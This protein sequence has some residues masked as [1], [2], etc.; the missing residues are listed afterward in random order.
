MDPFPYFEN[1]T[2]PLS[3]WSPETA[4][5]YFCGA[6][7]PGF[8][9]PFYGPHDVERVCEACLRSGRLAEVRLTTCQG[10]A[11]A[12]RGQLERMRPAI[13]DRALVETVS[14]RTADLQERT[15]G[16]RSWQDLLWPAH[17]GDYCCFIEELGKPEL[18]ELAA[19][20]DR[21]AWFLSRAPRATVAV[22]SAIRADSARLHPS[23]SYDLTVYRFTCRLCHATV[24]RWDAS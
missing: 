2:H 15:P 12:L 1:P 9:G 3:S 18:L 4:A 21:R 5:C 23:I 16:L 7:G 14:A 22:W 11:A 13:S 10:D 6:R 24:L 8:D 17:C 19:G 20:E